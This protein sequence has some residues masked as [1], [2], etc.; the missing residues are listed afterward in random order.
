MVRSNNNELNLNI[1]LVGN[2]SDLNEGRE[3]K[4]E[5]GEQKKNDFS[6]DGFIEISTKNGNGFEELFK[7]ISRILY[8]DIFNDNDIKSVTKRK[9]RLE[10]H[11]EIQDPNKCF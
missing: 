1:M 5:E 10:T 9:I 11:E 2:K 3:V 6:L 4:Y 8:D 7:Q